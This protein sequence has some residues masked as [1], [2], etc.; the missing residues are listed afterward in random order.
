MIDPPS[1]MSP[2]ACFNRKNGPR[3]VSPSRRS[4]L[5]S[6]TSS[7]G[8]SRFVP[9]LANTTSTR[10]WVARTCSTNALAAVGSPASDTMNSMPDICACAAPTDAALDPVATTVAPSARNS[11]AV[12]APMPLVPPVMRTILPSSFFMC[13][14]FQ[15][16]VRSMGKAD[17]IV[18]SS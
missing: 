4:K 14:L 9:A 5:A 8:A 17:A 15:A 13:C 18:P 12:A 11:V 10:P 3:S 6:S 1:N 7:M 2:T 16:V